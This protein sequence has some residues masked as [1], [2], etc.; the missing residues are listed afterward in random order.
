MADMASLEG[1][2]ISKETSLVNSGYDRTAPRRYLNDHNEAVPF[3]K[4]DSAPRTW[5]Y[6]AATASN[7]D[8]A[9]TGK[10]KQKTAEQRHLPIL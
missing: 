6:S 2:F 7:P 10:P 3:R 1:R 4:R 5:K 8:R 9:K